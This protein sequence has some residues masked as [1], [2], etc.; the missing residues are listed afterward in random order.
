MPGIAYATEKGVV[1]TVEQVDQLVQ[2]L[3]MCLVIFVSVVALALAGPGLWARLWPHLWDALRAGG[4]ALRW[5]GTW[6]RRASERAEELAEAEHQRR[7]ARLRGEEGVNHFGDDE[8]GESSL[9]MSEMADEHGRTRT[10][11]TDGRASAVD[12]VVAQLQ[13]DRTRTTVIEVMVYSGWT[14]AEIRGVVKGEN[15]TISEEVRAARARLGIAAPDASRTLR[16]RD[17]DGERVVPFGSQPTVQ[18]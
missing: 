8:A 4:A 12:P 3:L 9:I 1:V 16:V 14:V 18:K 10:D 15:A 11:E 2:V 17:Q 7:L 13:V 5:L 6:W